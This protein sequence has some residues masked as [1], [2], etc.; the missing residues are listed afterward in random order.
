VQWE[1]VI[2][3]GGLPDRMAHDRAPTLPLN[4][5]PVKLIEVKTEWSRAGGVTGADT[6]LNRYLGGLPHKDT[7]VLI[8]GLRCP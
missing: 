4:Q 3:G 1:T 8:P 6:Q 5:S 7:G 2:D